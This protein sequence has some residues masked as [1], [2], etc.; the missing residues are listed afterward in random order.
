V[1]EGY[2]ASKTNVVVVYG[3]EKGGYKGRRACCDTVALLM[4]STPSS[5]VVLTA[6]RCGPEN[7]VRTR[8]SLC[9]SLKNDHLQKTT[10]SVTAVANRTLRSCHCSRNILQPVAPL[11]VQKNPPKHLVLASTTGATERSR[12]PMSMRGTVLATR[13]ISIHAGGGHRLRGKPITKKLSLVGT[14]PISSILSS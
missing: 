6:N 5:C 1:G 13:R 2:T 14:P 10:Q 9:L 11:L 4:Q 8:G 7:P 3:W 12:Q